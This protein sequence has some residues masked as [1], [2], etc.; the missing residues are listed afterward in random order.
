MQKEYNI[1]AK[2]GVI[3]EQKA[4]LSLCKSNQECLSFDNV[5]GMETGE[6]SETYIIHGD[7]ASLKGK[8]NI[9]A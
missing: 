5:H 6:D 9:K 4:M 7:L 8:K 1:I 3:T 2:G